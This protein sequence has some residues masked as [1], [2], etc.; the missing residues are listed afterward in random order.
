MYRNPFDWGLI[1]NWI[2]FLNL[3]S[4]VEIHCSP[5][6]VNARSLHFYSL[7]SWRIIS[8]I[9]LPFSSGFIENGLTYELNIPTSQMI[10]ESLYDLDRQ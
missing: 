10:L 8:R 4:S 3:F 6:R 2:R 5:S 7:L 1:I 9:L